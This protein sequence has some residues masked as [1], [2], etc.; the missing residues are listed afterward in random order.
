MC[1]SPVSQGSDFMQRLI[2]FLDLLERMKLLNPSAVTASVLFHPATGGEVVRASEC[3]KICGL[4]NIFAINWFPWV[5]LGCCF[6]EH[7]VYCQN[8]LA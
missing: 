6:P 7:R 1:I 4:N 2:S 3:R 8:V 5:I